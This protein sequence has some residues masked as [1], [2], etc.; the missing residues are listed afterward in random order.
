MLKKYKIFLYFILNCCIILIGIYLKQSIIVII[1][2][3]IIVNITI[4]CFYIFAKYIN[5]R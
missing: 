5:K 1:Y 2:C 4:G 3:L